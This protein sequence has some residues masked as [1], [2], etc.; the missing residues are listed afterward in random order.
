MVLIIIFVLAGLWL[1]PGG[2]G[3]G[4]GLPLGSPPSAAP[5]EVVAPSLLCRPCPDVPLRRAGTP[6]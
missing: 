6:E 1:L 5:S 2:V 4:P 3:A